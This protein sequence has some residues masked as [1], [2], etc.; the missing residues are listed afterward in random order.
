MQRLTLFRLLPF[1]ALLAILALGAFLRLHGLMERELW[2]DEIFTGDLVRQPWPELTRGILNDVHPPLYYWL[3]KIWTYG[4]GDRAAA[5]RVFSVLF[6]VATIALAYAAFRQWQP[7][8]YWP[9]VIAALVVAID[10]FFVNYSQ[11]TRMYALL[12]FLVLLAAYLLTRAWSTHGTRSRWL[13]SLALSAALLTHHLAALSAVCF[14]VVETAYARREHYYKTAKT[15]FVWLVS[16]YGLP[17]LASLAWLPYFLAQAA[18]RGASLGWV[19]SVPLPHIA[20]SLHI[21]LFGVPVGVIGVP[22][23]LGY[24]VPWLSVPLMSAILTVFLLS[25]VIMLT[26]R[27]QW[28]AT[29]VLIAA[30]AFF[31]LLA[32]WLLQF[33]QLQLYVERFLIGSGI[34]VVIFPLLAT[35]RLYGIRALAGFAAVYILLVALIAP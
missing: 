33:A 19:P 21:F 9:A 20:V 2:F 17:L 12:T 27:K 28:D 3:L 23:A 32:T 6:G 5:L 35:A 22:P 10:P 25:L 34:F 13:F 16:G 18:N 11:E 1:A 31:P 14:F 7:K 8:H 30:L 4:F 29:L 26:R 15:H 24:R